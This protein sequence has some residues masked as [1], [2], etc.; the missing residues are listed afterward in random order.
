MTQR[1][2]GDYTE[3]YHTASTSEAQRILDV[4]LLPAG[5]EAVLHDRKDHAFPAAGQPGEVAIAV[6][7]DQ[8]EKSVDLITEAIENGYLKD[9]EGQIVG[10]VSG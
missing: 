2:A 1:K 5:I 6:P 8:R 3:V 10:E 7:M 4:I 9:L